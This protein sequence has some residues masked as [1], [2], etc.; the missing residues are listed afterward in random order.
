MSAGVHFFGRLRSKPGLP[1]RFGKQPAAEGGRCRP[2]QRLAGI[3]EMEGEPAG[4]AHG[5][6]GDE[7]AFLQ[8]SRYEG[9]PHQ[10]ETEPRLHR[11]VGAVAVHEDGATG[12]ID[13][14]RARRFQP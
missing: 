1:L 8:F 14:A 4:D 7:L 5:E 9:A 10:R 2:L 12:G 13:I 3:D 6:G 11:L